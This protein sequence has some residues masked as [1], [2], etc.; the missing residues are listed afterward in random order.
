MSDDHKINAKKALLL[1]FAVNL[2]NFFDRQLPGVLGEPIRK[3]F[4]LTDAQLGLLGTA[5]TLV[6]AAVGLPIAPKTRPLVAQVT[7]GEPTHSTT[8]PKVTSRPASRMVT[9]S[10]RESS[11]SIP[12]GARMA[13]PIT[14][15]PNIRAGL[16]SRMLMMTR[17]TPWGRGRAI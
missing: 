5:F 15:F 4:G 9:A 17:A 8:A 14:K 3:E 1:L 7:S 16:A 12:A 13:T 2:L 6:Y 10:P 11:G